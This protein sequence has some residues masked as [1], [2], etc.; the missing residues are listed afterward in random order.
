MLIMADY[1]SATMITG[2]ATANGSTAQVG[3]QVG[4]VIGYY[5]PI[6]SGSAQT[7]GVNGGT[8]S[9]TVSLYGNTIDGA[10]LNMYLR[11]VIPVNEKGTSLSLNFSDLD[12]TP[13]N[14]PSGFYESL[15]FYGEG[16]LPSTTFTSFNTIDALS[17]ATVTNTDTSTNNDITV[18]FTG[19][20]FDS[21]DLWLHLQFHATSSFDS[22]TWKNTQEL[23]SANMTTTADVPE[24]GSLVLMAIGL[25]SLF[26]L[27][28]LQLKPVR[29]RKRRR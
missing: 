20:N 16:G 10:L 5:I 21:G 3:D 8:S 9:D 19:L 25:L 29:I 2:H 17:N 14:D 23:L 6:A 28:R 27:R 1:A 18:D 22:G 12:L 15:R 26:G 4:G 7:Y 11:F 24:P 13:Y